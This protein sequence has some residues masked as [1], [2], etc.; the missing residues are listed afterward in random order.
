MIVDPVVTEQSA[1]GPCLGDGWHYGQGL[2]SGA[3]EVIDQGGVAAA[4]QGFVGKLVV[5]PLAT[6]Y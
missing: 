1:L 3:A 6:E 5:D 4:E 2:V